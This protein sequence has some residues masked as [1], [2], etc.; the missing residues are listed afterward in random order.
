MLFSALSL[1]VK[2]IAISAIA[3]A[4]VGGSFYVAWSWRD[5]QAEKEVRDAVG[6]AVVKKVEEIREELREERAA[7]IQ[8]Q[9]NA[10]KMLI[11]LADAVQQVRSLRGQT[12]VLVAQ[13]RAANKSFYDQPLPEAGRQAWLQARSLAV[14]PPDL[15]ASSAQP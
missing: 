12:Q 9:I 13:D 4:L 2:L 11:A 6:N 14:A 8:A 7:R 3:V 15:P 10:D 1:K 5:A